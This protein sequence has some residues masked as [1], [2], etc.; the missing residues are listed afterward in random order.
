[1]HNGH[2]RDLEVD[3][4]LLITH[5]KHQLK[6]GVQAL[7][8]FEHDYNPN[9]FNGTYVFGDRRASVLDANNNPTG[10]TTT[11]SA[12]EQ[13]HRVQNNLPGGIPT[14]YQVTGGIPL[15]PLTQWRVGLYVQDIIKLGPHFTVNVGLR[16]IRKHFQRSFPAALGTSLRGYLRARRLLPSSPMIGW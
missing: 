14:T 1:M 7:G 3:D 11:I 8:I 6:F 2:T 4:D 15:V 5:G 10:Q 16:G 9:N 13:Y 12:I